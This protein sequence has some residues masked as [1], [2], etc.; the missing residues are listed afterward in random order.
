MPSLPQKIADERPTLTTLPRLER[1][2][3]IVA[4]F[5]LWFP[6]WFLMEDVLGIGEVITAISVNVAYF[7]YKVAMIHYFGG[8]IGH[9]IVGARVV[10][11]HTGGRVGLFRAFL[12]TLPEAT[13]YWW[14]IYI[15]NAVMVALR[16]D[17]RH[18]GD[19]MGSTVVVKRKERRP[20]VR[21]LDPDC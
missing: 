4:E 2:I 1:G 15:V 14:L 17:R 19:M 5:V 20:L 21:Y 10:D 7:C 8:R 16:D 6:V 3:G 11:Y 18:V 9:L 13:G 12:R